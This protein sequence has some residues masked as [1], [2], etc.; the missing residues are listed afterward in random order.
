M[1]LESLLALTTLPVTIATVEGIRH[2]R[3]NDR[4]SKDADEQYRMQDF[5]LDVYC[6]STSRKRDQVDGTMVVLRDEKVG[7]LRL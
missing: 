2:Q 6:S 1:V 7:I 3:Q 4:E 5:H